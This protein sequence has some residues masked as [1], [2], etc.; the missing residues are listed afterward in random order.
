[1]KV[2]ARQHYFKNLILCDRITL[3]VLL[4]QYDS[5]ALTSET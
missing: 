1:M 5:E 4:I 2:F 3:R